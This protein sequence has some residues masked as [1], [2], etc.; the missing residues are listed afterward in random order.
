MNMPRNCSQNRADFSKKKKR[1]KK[2][3]RCKG[4]FFADFEMKDVKTD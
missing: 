4:N 2:R 3:E 1:R